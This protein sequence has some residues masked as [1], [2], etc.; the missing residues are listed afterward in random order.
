MTLMMVS[1]MAI[2]MLVIMRSMF[3]SPRLNTVILGVA[4]LAFV[5]GFAGTRPQ[6][7]VGNIE[8]LRSMIPHHS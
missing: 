6:A 7:A 2:V 8:F 1:S 3:P 4:A 5:V